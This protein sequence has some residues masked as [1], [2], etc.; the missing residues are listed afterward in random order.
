MVSQWQTS[1]SIEPFLLIRSEHCELRRDDLVE[2]HQILRQ[3]NWDPGQR[4]SEI[5]SIYIYIYISASKYCK[6]LL[7]QIK[8]KY[9][10]PQNEDCQGAIVNLKLDYCV[11]FLRDFFPQFHFPRPIF[12]G[13]RDLCSQISHTI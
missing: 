8:K 4:F 7:L 9:V 12:H 10:Q 1:F 5:A 11:P 6:P 13:I 3:S 2:G